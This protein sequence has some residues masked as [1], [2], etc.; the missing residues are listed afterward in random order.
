MDFTYQLVIWTY[1]ALIAIGVMLSKF[2]FNQKLPFL[3]LWLLFLGGELLK[4]VMGIFVAPFYRLIWLPFHYSSLPLYLL[5]MALF[6]KKP[7]IWWNLL[8]TVSFVLFV[9]F[10]VGP[11]DI[12]GPAPYYMAGMRSGT[13]YMLVRHWHSYV[14]HTISSLT[15]ILLIALKPYHFRM[16]E[17]FCSLPPYLLILTILAFIANTTGGNVASFLGFPLW[18]LNAIRDSYGL[19]LFQVVLLSLY[20]GA[21]FLGALVI[22]AIQKVRS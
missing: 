14:A 10:L 18:G 22:L 16:R 5:P 8:F 15:F 13:A 12:M 7:N 3:M 20:I 4:Q 21:V 17:F 19:H 9:G 6:S 1:L 2:R 11:H